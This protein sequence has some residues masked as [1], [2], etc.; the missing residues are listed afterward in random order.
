MVGGEKDGNGLP[1]MKGGRDV[2]T[3]RDGAGNPL[4]GV[5]HK[6]M[7]ARIRHGRIAARVGRIGQRPIARAHGKNRAFDRIFL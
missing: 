3:Q 5:K 4:H 1:S 2:V 7:A 6:K